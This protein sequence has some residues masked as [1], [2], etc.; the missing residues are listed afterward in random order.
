[1][2]DV[3]DFSPV[4]RRRFIRQRRLRS[5]GSRVIE[6]AAFLPGRDPKIVSEWTVLRPWYPVRRARFVVR[7]YDKAR[8]FAA[9][10]KAGLDAVENVEEP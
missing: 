6:E 10:R 1:L 7:D 9:L 8:L 4:R 2:I 5:D 3:A